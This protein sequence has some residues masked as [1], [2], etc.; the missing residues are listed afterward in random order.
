MSIYVLRSDNLIKIGFSDDIRARVGSIV[1]GV[2]VPVEFVGHMPGGRDVEAHF[3]SLFDANRF[4]GEWF[5]ETREM[6]VLFDALLIPKLPSPPPRR[7]S[8]PKRTSNEVAEVSES[9][10]LSAAERWPADSH[11]TRITNLANALGW[12]RSRVKDCY[13]RDPRV[14]MR[15]FEKEEVAAFRQAVRVVARAGT[16][17]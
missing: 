13:Y 9:L 8:D 6:R 17:G 4:S 2:P 15:A 11:A 7:D 12:N 1:S 5:V 10:R 14:A 16:E 3:H